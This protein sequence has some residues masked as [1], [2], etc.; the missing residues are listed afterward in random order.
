MSSATHGPHRTA[1][2]KKDYF[3]QIEELHM[4]PLWQVMDDLMP[5]HPKP[6]ETPYQWKWKE[7]RPLVYK[8]AELVSIENAV[9]RVLMLLNPSL[10]KELAASTQTLYAGIQILLPGEVA[11]AHRH[12][13]NALRFVMEGQG[14]FTTV[15]GEK[16]ILGPG[17]VV[18]TPTWTWHDHGNESQGPVV[19]LDAL[20]IPLVN[21]LSGMFY[22]DYPQKH[23]PVSDVT[24]SSQRTY[25]RGLRPVG[26]HRS[27]TY[28]PILNYPYSASKEALEGLPASSHHPCDGRILEYV[29]PLTGGPIL[30]TMDAYLQRLDPG[31]ELAPHR[32]SSSAIYM[33]VQGK[34]TLTIDGQVFTW[35]PFDV[36]VVP[37]WAQHS[38]RA[39]GKEPAILFSYSNAPTMKALALYREEGPGTA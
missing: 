31:Q 35:E 5:V 14:A 25:G 19:W 12:T 4:H 22:E 37:A 39:V 24:N 17:D 26:D 9:R 18:T 23:Q 28:S 11:P 30:P 36:I 21:A 27:L 34:G 20:D 13:P 6:L 15:S 2:A 3:E 29:N 7:I 16:T 32:H 1:A 10:P 38:H 8:A 33:G